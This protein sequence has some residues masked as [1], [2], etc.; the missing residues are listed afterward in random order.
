MRVNLSIIPLS[1]ATYTHQ[2]FNQTLYIRTKY[3]KKKSTLS[4]V[5]L[6]LSVF[7]VVVVVVVVVHLRNII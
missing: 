1:N 7:L 3:E 6:S 2:L 4:V 5:S